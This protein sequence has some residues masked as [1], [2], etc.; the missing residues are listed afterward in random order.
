[1]ET[2]GHY[3]FVGLFVLIFTVCLFAFVVWISKTSFSHR[4]SIYQIYFTGSVTGLKET[5]VVRYRGIPI[6]TVKS[7]ELDHENLEKVLV[8]IGVNQ[9]IPIKEDVH[10]SLEIQG[11]TGGIYV[12]LNGGTQESRVLT[13][14]GKD[15]YPVIQSKSSTLEEVVDSLPQMM[16]KI[17]ELVQ[18]LKEVTTK[19]NRAHFQNILENLSEFTENLSGS[20]GKGLIQDLK[21]ATNQFTQTLNQLTGVAKEVNTIL[22]ENRQG[23]KDFSNSGLRNLNKFLAEGSEAVSTF[24]RIGEAIE[25]SPTRF[26]FNDPTQGYK[27]NR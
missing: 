7:I 2:K 9:D 22:A 19:E 12:Q 23:L 20:N 3:T 16:S 5:S 18:Q 15:K 13:P 21:A 8:T 27:V 1:M 17:T 14:K 25:R 24:K 10:A 11:I 4:E 26:L 6:G